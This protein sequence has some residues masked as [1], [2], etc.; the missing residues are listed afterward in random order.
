VSNGIKSFILVSL[1]LVFG[2]NAFAGDAAHKDCLCRAND[3]TYTQGEL[4][5]LKGGLARCEMNQNVPTWKIVSKACPQ[6]KISYPF[7]PIVISTTVVDMLQL[8]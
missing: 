7:S 5:C 1:T 8:H 6:A 3:K 4:V 2:S